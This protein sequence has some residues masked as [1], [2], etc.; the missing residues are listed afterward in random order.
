MTL[1]YFSAL[2]HTWHVFR[3]KLIE[4]KIRVLIFSTNFVRKIFH[5]KQNRARYYRK[6]T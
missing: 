5:S 4:Q 2:F 3:E 6:C 1:P